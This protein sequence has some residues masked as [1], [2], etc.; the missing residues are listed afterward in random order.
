MI[1]EYLD[2]E[3]DLILAYIAF[4]LG[5]LGYNEEA[6]SENFGESLDEEGDYSARTS[7]YT[8]EEWIH[9]I[10]RGIPLYGYGGAEYTGCCLKRRVAYIHENGKKLVIEVWKALPKKRDVSQSKFIITETSIKDEIRD[11]P[12]DIIIIHPRAQSKRDEFLEAKRHVEKLLGK[13]IL[14]TAKEFLHQVG[15]DKDSISIVKDDWKNI[16]D[17]VIIGLEEK[18]PILILAVNNR[19]IRQIDEWLRNARVSLD[20]KMNLDHVITD[21]GNAVEAMLQALYSTRKATQ[22]KLTFNDLLGLQKDKIA[23]MFGEDILIDMSF[24][25]D[26]RNSVNH[27]YVQPPDFVA[28]L[29]VVTKA[30]LCYQIFLERLWK[31]QIDNT[32]D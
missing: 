18:N 30:E 21:C 5:T 7:K 27:P 16:R 28:A 13:D 22:D 29:K 24:I 25:K 9:E 19:R 10:I 12:P 17:E 11:A 4:T 2:G 26:Q 31:P 3:N 14:V 8:K 1:S 32:G 20:Q 15:L 23:D 6:L